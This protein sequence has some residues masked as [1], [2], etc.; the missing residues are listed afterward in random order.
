VEHQG[1]NTINL[2]ATHIPH[3]VPLSR[4]RRYRVGNE[5]VKLKEGKVGGRR[6]FR[7]I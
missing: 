2:T 3:V 6:V 5:T 4:G 1:R 7:I